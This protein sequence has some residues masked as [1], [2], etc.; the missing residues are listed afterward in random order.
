MRL[1]PGPICATITLICLSLPAQAATTYPFTL[2]NCGEQITIAEAPQR[3]VSIGQNS[4]E[5][6]L[7]LGLADRMVGTST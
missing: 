6:L 3:A 7:M 1:L 4:S 2:E 5:I